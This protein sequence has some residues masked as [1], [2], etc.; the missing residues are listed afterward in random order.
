MVG[1]SGDVTGVEVAVQLAGREQIFP[2]ALD[3]DGDVLVPLM[4][5]ES[6][7]VALASGSLGG[8]GLGAGC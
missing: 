7:H 3:T 6:W 2:L 4:S 5:L 8:W 1:V